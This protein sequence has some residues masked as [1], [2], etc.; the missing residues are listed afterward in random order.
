LQYFVHHIRCQLS[1]VHA[2]KALSFNKWRCG[3]NGVDQLL[4][5]RVNKSNPESLGNNQSNALLLNGE[6]VLLPHNE[7]IADGVV[8]RHRCVECTARSSF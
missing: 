6:L 8:A 7:P 1:R 5:S 3:R 4:L 2:R